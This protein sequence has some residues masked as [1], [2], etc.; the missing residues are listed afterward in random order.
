MAVSRPLRALLPL[1]AATLVVALLACDGSSNSPPNSFGPSGPL[2]LS[3]T[4]ADS[5]VAVGSGP[6]EVIAHL[7]RNGAPVSAQTVSFSTSRGSIAPANSQTDGSGDA[8]AFFTPSA[9]AGT[10]I[11]TTSAV[12][13]ING[14]TRTCSTNVSVTQPRDP[15][16]N[17]QLITPS[18]VAGLN[19]SVVYDSSRVTLPASGI[20]P[21]TPFTANDCVTIT[22]DNDAGLVTLNMACPTLRT[23]SGD[24]ARFEFQHVSGDELTLND[25]DVTCSA[26]NESG[27]S[28]SAACSSTVLQ[29]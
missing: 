9:T 17:V 7:T 5:T 2:T 23:T 11:I 28:V 25:F 26:F 19:I 12:D 13:G 22:N 3:C 8:I 20:D 18:A 16:L 6:T 27:A 14:E 21:M 10:A 15:R 24:V 4:T 29:L 1:A